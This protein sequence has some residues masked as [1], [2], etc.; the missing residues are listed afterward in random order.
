MAWWIV[1]TAEYQ[2]GHSSSSHEKKAVVS[3]FGTQAT[4]APA[5]SDA[6]ITMMP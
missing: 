6:S 2:V 1:G 3:N 4:P 5:R